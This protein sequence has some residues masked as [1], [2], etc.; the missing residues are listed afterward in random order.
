[1]KGCNTSY[2]RAVV[3]RKC[4]GCLCRCTRASDLSALCWLAA[5]VFADSGHANFCSSRRLASDLQFW[6]LATIIR[7]VFP[8][9][10]AEM[11]STAFGVGESNWNVPVWSDTGELPRI[12]EFLCCFVPKHD[13][14]VVAENGRVPAENRTTIMAIVFGDWQ[15]TL[16]HILW[17]M[18]RGGFLFFVDA[19]RLPASK[20]EGRS[21]EFP[22]SVNLHNVGP[23]VTAESLP[24]LL[25]SR[26]VPGS[27]L[28][29][30]TCYP[31]WGL[32]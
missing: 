6:A 24:L 9:V 13:L 17:V 27:D 15:L 23:F 11:I 2:F 3:I 21:L 12:V 22:K 10:T 1:M 29:P 31:A 30:E 7:S 14:N 8:L 20:S 28:R 18:R 16:S 32:P 25:L 4:P 19:D 26:E 5:W